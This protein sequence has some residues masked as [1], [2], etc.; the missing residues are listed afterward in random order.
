M[1]RIIPHCGSFNP[2]SREGS[3][4]CLIYGVF[5]PSVS[6][7]APAKGATCPGKSSAST[8]SRFN[9][10]SR[11]GSDLKNFERAGAE[12]VSIHA[13]A[14]GATMT[15]VYLSPVYIEFQS[16]LPRRERLVAGVITAGQ[17]AVFQST[18]PRRERRLCCP[19][20]LAIVVCFN[21]RSR[22]GSDD[23][24][25]LT[26]D[27]NH[28]SFNPRSREGSDLNRYGIVPYLSCFNP[29]SREGSDNSDG[30]LYTSHNVSIHAPAKGA[31]DDV[32]FCCQII[33]VS[34]HAPAK[35]ATMT[36]SPGFVIVAFQSTLPR[37]ERRDIH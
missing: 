5:L 26:V 1:I 4:L 27:C 16:T 13:P 20:P 23:Y 32:C 9:P 28:A 37:R 33:C 25:F 21:P 7:H 34:I 14:K 8:H 24:I 6:I 29:R 35:G 31:T 19:S 36:S 11:E 10:R 12:Y 30:F 17:G 3:D 22:E 2:R 18:L 15:D